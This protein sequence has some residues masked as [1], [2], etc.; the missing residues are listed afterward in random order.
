M[1]ICGLR[2]FLDGP[3]LISFLIYSGRETPNV[4]RAFI[5]L[6]RFRTRGKV[7]LIRVR[8]PCAHD[9]NVCDSGSKCKTKFQRFVRL[10]SPNFGWLNRLR[11]KTFFKIFIVHVFQKIFALILRP[12]TT[13][14]KTFWPFGPHILR[15]GTA[16]I[17]DMHFQIW[18]TAEHVPKFGWDLFGHV[19]VNKENV[20]TCSWWMNVSISAICGPNFTRRECRK[21]LVV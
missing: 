7:C 20:K 15:K 11:F 8:W 21:P 9:G 16:R 2:F 19:R 18:L 1:A 5:N 10:S 3:L 12:K 17:F 13:Q 4:G 14:N 6:A